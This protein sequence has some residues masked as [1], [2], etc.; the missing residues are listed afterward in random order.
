MVMQE[1][2]L[3][4][5]RSISAERNILVE[6]VRRWGGPTSDAVLDPACKI[7]MAPGIE[8]LIGY[9]DEPGC[10]VAYGDPVCAFKDIPALTSAFHRYC[11]QIKKEIVYIATLKSFTKWA[12]ENICSTSIEF[13]VE[14]TISPQNDPKKRVGPYA[15]LVRRKVRRAQQIGTIV[16][17]YKGGDEALEKQFEELAISWLAARK[18]PQVYIAHVNLFDDR[19]GKRWLYATTQSKVVGIIVLNRL[20][21]QNGWLLNKLM[22]AND[23]LHG[24]PEMLVTSALDILREEGCKFATFGIAPSFELGEINGM[25]KISTFL[26]RQI[27]RCAYRFLSLQGL[28]KFWEKYHPQGEPCYLLFSRK[29]VGWKELSGL[30]QALNIGFLSSNKK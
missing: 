12:L 11:A 5:G 30:M 22:I 23:A 26:A 2:S 27:Y 15:Q 21:E 4:E 6:Y 20:E 10:I 19:L 7:F 9:R 8:G 16:Q 29:A 3:I 14:L 1:S 18:G 25:G 24:T 17:E 13:G 28:R